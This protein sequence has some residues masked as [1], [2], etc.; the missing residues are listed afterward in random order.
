MNIGILGTGMVGQALASELAGQGHAVRVGRRDVNETLA[1]SAPDYMGNPPFSAWQQQNPQVQLGTFAEA[2]AHG[3]L[4]FNSTA[5]VGSLDALNRAGAANL[6]GK[7]LIDVAN[8]LDFSQGLPPSLAV[9]NIDSLGEQIQCAFP[10]V[11][12]VKTLNTLVAHLMLN[13]GLIGDGDHTLFL[14][15]NDAAAKAQV[16]ELLQSFG[17]RTIIDLGDISSARA[18]EMMVPLI[19]RLFGVCQSV[20]IN[21]KLVR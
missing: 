20:M 18:T 9:C 11:K 13:P 5:G 8:P 4:L 2:A 16:T 3:E 12:V 7:V 10:A 21:V 19:L 6:N 1:R 17:W 15:G 14:S